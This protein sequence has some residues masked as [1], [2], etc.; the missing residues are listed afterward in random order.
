MAPTILVRRRKHLCLPPKFQKQLTAKTR[1][2]LEPALRHSLP[3]LPLAPSRRMGGYV[4]GFG[5]CPSLHGHPDIH[6]HF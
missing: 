3:V 1:L 5:M 6:Y 4:I 2:T